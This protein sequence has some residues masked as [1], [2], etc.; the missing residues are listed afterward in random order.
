MKKHLVITALI[1][2]AITNFSAYSFADELDDL[3]RLQE[4]F[5]QA[6]STPIP[7]VEVVA[8]SVAKPI[9][10]MPLFKKIRIKITNSY[11]L[12]EYNKEKKLLEKEQ[13]KIKA[14]EQKANEVT[15]P[16]VE[17]IVQDSSDENLELLGGVNQQVTS[18]NVQLDAD[19]I[20]Y[21]EKT[22]D[23]IATGSPVLYFPPQ[24]VTIKSDK[25]IYNT[26][27][28]VLKALDKVE[29][30]K[31]GNSIFG[32]NLEINLNEENAY[33]DNIETKA[34]CLT[35]TARKSKLD[36]DTIILQDGAVESKEPYVFKF[37]TK[38]VGGDRF[39]A[40]FVNEED[41]NFMLDDVGE[42]PV[43]ITT[44]EII[45]DA[46]KNTD[47]I[48]MKN[49]KFRI[50]D[51][52]IFSMKKLKMHTNKNQE[53]FEGNYP[54]IG[55]R[56]KFGMFL[57]P[58]YTFDTPLQNGSTLKVLPIVNY[59]S[60]FGIGGFLKY[61]SGTNFTD[62]GYA[63]ASSLVF[64]RGKQYL[65][66]KLYIQY[67]ANSYMDEWFMGRRMAKYSAELV[68]EDTINVPSTIGEDKDLEFRHR[69][70]FGYMHNGDFNRYGENLS[71]NNMGTTRTRYMA[72]AKQ[73]LFKRI[74]K[75]NR[76]AVELSL[77][78]QGSAALYGT[79][80]TQFIGRIGPNLHTQY[81]YWMQDIGYFAS[82]FEDNTPLKVYDT[83]RYG[84]GS[85]VIREA[86]RLHKYVSLAWS[87]NINVTGDSPNNKMFQECTFFVSLGPDDFKVHL[88]YDWVREHTY[89]A[90]AVAMNTKGSGLKYKKMVIKHAERLGQD[91]DEV[92][93][94]KVFDDDKPKVS[95]KKMMYAEVIDI[96][97][98]DKEQL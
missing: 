1:L 98:P 45:V 81:K 9:N 61:R 79:G 21:D 73:T 34:S 14:S 92:V 33:L 11:N 50:A 22:M 53:Y 66:D 69:M 26:A 83:Y 18:N 39:K 89:F 97:D 64:L 44:D 28:N 25:I 63:T 49:F 74:D 56:G 24:D 62:F 48:T 84:Q 42:D 60:G 12:R 15:K 85:I 78:M 70:G 32:E 51:H 47:T 54:E 29:I 8:G 71:T 20:D 37:H 87:G 91:D 36:G 16:V 59:K 46:K 88:G 30:I 90:F 86:L 17:D 72:Q 75:E 41:R 80:D 5:Y 77:L 31:N 43:S 57:G 96:E 4:Q 13:E 27:S 55:T 19:Y 94:L 93:E 82:A 65:D 3:D 35:V 7:D 67:G 52:K 10:S 6:P 58:G 95:S 38:M 76:K 40:M 23:I 2:S 68:Y